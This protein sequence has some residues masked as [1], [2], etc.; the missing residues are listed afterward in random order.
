MLVPEFTERE[1]LWFCVYLLAYL[2]V[3]TEE[4]LVWGLIGVLALESGVRNSR[5]GDGDASQRLLRHRQ[6]CGGPGSVPRS[7]SEEP[8]RRACVVGCAKSHH[9]FRI[10]AGCSVSRL[11]EGPLSSLRRRAGRPSLSR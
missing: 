1:G 3:F 11:A 9:P 4:G 8:S 5:S 10:L 2:L 6:G 7:C